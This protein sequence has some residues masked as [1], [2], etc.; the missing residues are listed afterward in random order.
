MKISLPYRHQFAYSETHTQ[1]LSTAHF[2][3]QQS[4]IIGEFLTFSTY[5]IDMYW[6]ITSSYAVIELSKLV[7]LDDIEQN[8]VF[9]RRWGCGA[10]AEVK[11]TPV[12]NR[13]AS[14]ACAVANSDVEASPVLIDVWNLRAWLNL[15]KSCW[16]EKR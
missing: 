14:S 5:P 6:R 9:N 13:K 3:I 16:N 15:Y 4:H 12:A 1:V 11:T 8:N 10:R 7:L 2:L